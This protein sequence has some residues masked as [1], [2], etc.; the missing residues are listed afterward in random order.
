MHAG[1]HYTPPRIAP[2]APPHLPQTYS[3]YIVMY[4]QICQFFL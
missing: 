3:A 1:I 4:D 2:P